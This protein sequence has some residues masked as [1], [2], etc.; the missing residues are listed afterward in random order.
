MKDTRSPNNRYIWI[1]QSKDQTP[2]FLI[3]KEDE[4]KLWHNKIGH[5]N[6]K[7]MRIIFDKAINGL[8]N[9]KIEEGQ[10]YGDCQIGK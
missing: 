4:T 1:S 10:F 9:L 2:A 3:T 6:L 7:S 8:P 5:V